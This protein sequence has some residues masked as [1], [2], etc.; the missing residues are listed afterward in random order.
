M[1]I[2]VRLKKNRFANNEHTACLGSGS[3]SSVEKFGFIANGKSLWD[4]GQG[5][6]ELELGLL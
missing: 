5:Y 3:S 2:R 4:M 1:G 6:G